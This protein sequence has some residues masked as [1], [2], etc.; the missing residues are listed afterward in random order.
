MKILMDL[1]A[2]KDGDGLFEKVRELF[3]KVGIKMYD[4]RGVEKSLYALCCEVAE[5]MNEEK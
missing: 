3:E 5:L 1:L 4:E 2:S